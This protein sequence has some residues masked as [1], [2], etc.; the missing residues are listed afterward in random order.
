MSSCSKPLLG[1]ERGEREG[2]RERGEEREEWER[3]KERKKEVG[4]GGVAKGVR[5]E[6]EKTV[7]KQG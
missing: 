2:R 6:K 5:G 7:M 4:G 3:K 1:K